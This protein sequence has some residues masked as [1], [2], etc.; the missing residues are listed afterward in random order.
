MN[1]DSLKN[2]ISRFRFCIRIYEGS[3]RD[4]NKEIKRHQNKIK[5]FEKEIE[6]FKRY[7]Q[8]CRVALKGIKVLK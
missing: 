3:I 8:S 4:L 2:D 1:K 6:K 7:E 5:K